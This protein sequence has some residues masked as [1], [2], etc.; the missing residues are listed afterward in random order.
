MSRTLAPPS[1]TSC[2]AFP[3]VHFEVSGLCLTGEPLNLKNLRSH[4]ASL[5]EAG[6]VNKGH[7]W[8]VLHKFL[9]LGQSRTLLLLGDEGVGKTALL[10]AFF[11]SANTLGSD[12]FS[13]HQ[14]VKIHLGKLP[15]KAWTQWELDQL[16][17]EAL[18][19]WA[20]E[21]LQSLHMQGNKTLHSTGLILSEAELN[22]T[23]K[24]A[25]SLTLQE[26]RTTLWQTVLTQALAKRQN[27][28]AQWMKSGQASITAAG[29]VFNHPWGLIAFKMKEALEDPHMQGSIYEIIAQLGRDLK[30]YSPTLETKSRFSII[31][32][33]WE[34]L[35]HQKEAQQW[36]N[37]QCLSQI[38]KSINTQKRMPLQLILATRSEALSQQL[39]LGT[40]G[41]FSEQ[42]LLSGFTAKELPALLAL[43]PSTYPFPMEYLDEFYARSGA[44]SRAI[45]RLFQAWEAKATQRGEKTLSLDALNDLAVKGVQD[46]D[47]FIYARFHMDALQYGMPFLKAL[48]V[49]V[50]YL[51]EVPFLV[52]DFIAQRLSETQENLSEEY[53]ALALRKLFLYG[54]LTALP[55]ESSFEQEPRYVMSSRA[56]LK[57]V[58]L[59]FRNTDCGEPFNATEGSIEDR[60]QQECAS[61]LSSMTAPTESLMAWLPKLFEAGDCTPKKISHLLNHMAHSSNIEANVFIDTLLSFFKEK[62]ENAQNTEHCSK[63]LMILSVL[64]RIE[65]FNALLDALAHAEFKVKVSSLNALQIWLNRYAETNP[66]TVASLISTLMTHLYSWE[67]LPVNEK[68]CLQNLVFDLLTRVYPYA[69]KKVVNAFNEIINTLL[70]EENSEKSYLSVECFN[71]LSTIVKNTAPD[72]L[73]QALPKVAQVLKLALNQPDLKDQALNLLSYL[74]PQT[75]DLHDFLGGM[76][77]QA[78]APLGAFE[79]F[80]YA[81]QHLNASP[82]LQERVMATLKAI[83]T[84]ENLIERLK[85]SE[86]RQY[87][88]QITLQ[89]LKVSKQWPQVNQCFLLTLLEQVLREAIWQDYLDLFW[90]SLRLVRQLKGSIPRDAYAWIETLETSPTSQLVK[91]LLKQS[92]LDV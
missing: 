32:D 45:F 63:A 38:L 81:S 27:T 37:L 69:P 89:L 31:I 10:N 76:D 64:P 23:L 48:E 24:E 30:H 6:L 80:V 22:Q 51:D 35:L 7:E 13:Q 79:V 47:D 53:L 61:F 9:T 54:V 77:D 19:Q 36:Q 43:Y 3:L 17:Q 34:M 29:S 40:Y 85:H 71:A 90:L 28:L 20:T 44:S 49:V 26:E 56:D 68:E 18:H 86:F 65:A 58:A 75:P 72:I 73:I 2:I 55:N 1:I 59:F 21:L 67:H 11:K 57:R 52:R 15:K 46:L 62:W 70:I 33:E 12:E 84:N 8:Q 25:I 4:E 74:P 16:L 14:G 88:T 5:L 39:A 50:A 60:L 82:A 83:Y 92:E 66:Y 87:F 42:M 91:R 41:L 78:S